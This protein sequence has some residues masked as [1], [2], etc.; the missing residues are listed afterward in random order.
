MGGWYPRWCKPENNQRIILG[1]IKHFFAFPCSS[2]TIALASRFKFVVLF[3]KVDVFYISHGY[4]WIWLPFLGSRATST[5]F[6]S[7]VSHTFEGSYEKGYNP[8]P[9]F[10]TL[11]QSLLALTFHS[12]ADTI[13]T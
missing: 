2:E 11:R 7:R 9:N 1:F 13:W 3:R 8:C 12:S 10:Y 4:L 5:A 6:L